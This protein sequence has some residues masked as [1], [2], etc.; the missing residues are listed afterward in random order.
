MRKIILIYLRK[1]KKIT[2]YKTHKVEQASRLRVKKKKGRAGVSPASIWNPERHRR[3]ACSTEEFVR[4]QNSVPT[5]II[6]P[7]NTPA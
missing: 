2:I 3:D 4:M 6:S 1:T 7:P 5:Q